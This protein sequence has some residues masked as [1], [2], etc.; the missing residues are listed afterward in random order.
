MNQ[1]NYISALIIIALTVGVIF[2]IANR[3]KSYEW[4]VNLKE[5]GYQPYDLGFFR[6][7]LSETF[8]DDFELIK[9]SKQFELA[10]DSG[11]GTMIY[12]EDGIK[13]SEDHIERLLGFIERGNTAFFSSDIIPENL[14]EEITGVD[15][16][17]TYSEI[18]SIKQ[19]T[20]PNSFSLANSQPEGSPYNYEEEEEEIES[21]KDYQ[22]YEDFEVSHN[23]YMMDSVAQ[24][25]FLDEDSINYTFKFIQKDSLEEYTWNGIDSVI[26]NEYNSED[27]FHPISV[28]NDSLIYYFSMEYG[29]GELYVHLN[30]ILFSNIYF[31]ENSGFNYVNRIFEDFKDGE[32]YYNQHYTYL[33]TESANNIDYNRNGPSPLTFILKHKSLKWTLYTILIL[34]LIYI[35]FSFKRRLPVIPYFG[36][37][38]NTSISYVKALSSFY[39]SAKDHSIL[40]EEMMVNFKHYLRNRYRLNTNMEKEELI[41][42]IARNSGLPEVDISAIF[43]KEFRINFSND[44]KSKGLVDLYKS[45]ESFYSYCK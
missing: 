15:F 39:L 22:E 16:D 32:I 5:D 3:N 14:I 42:L 10:A 37:P 29:E 30:P 43:D 25:K 2:F 26:F 31:K 11:S 35:I 34:S 19:N 28:L 36:S 40:A 45:L 4:K 9:K 8:E 18:I 38:K 1:K 7:V 24:V 20:T 17:V 21:A 6:D 23:L 13:L 44:S 27:D 41:P 12:V 33:S